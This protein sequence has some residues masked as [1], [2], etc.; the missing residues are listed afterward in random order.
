MNIARQGFF[1]K[2]RKATPKIKVIFHMVGNGSDIKKH[3]RFVKEGK[4]KKYLVFYGQ[5]EKSYID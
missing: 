1:E 3:K 2:L 4:L 5:M